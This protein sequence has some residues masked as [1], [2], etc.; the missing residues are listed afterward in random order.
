MRHSTPELLLRIAQADAYGISAEFMNRHPEEPEYQELLEMKRYQGHPCY[1]GIIPARYTDDGQ[2][3]IAVAETLIENGAYPAGVLFVAKF[4]EVFDRDRRKGYSPGF[5]KILEESTDWRA[6]LS[7]LKGASDKNGAA[8]RSVPIGVI[9]DPLTVT[10]VAEKQ[11]V[12]THN[13]WGGIR[14]SQ[15]VAL[16]AHFALHEPGELS[17]LP[18]Y[19]VHH[20]PDL[21]FFKTPWEGAVDWKNVGI[22]TAHA[23]CTLASTKKSLVEIMRQIIVWGGDTDTVAACAWGI[24]CPRMREEKLPEFFDRDLEP[25]GQYGPAF[26]LDLGTRL[27]KEF[28]G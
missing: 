20:L 1:E 3:S 15:A 8:M 10:M 11:A 5:Q 12:M 24:A 22:K 21:D 18:D 13:T 6:M 28:G 19:V 14:S 2:M 4:F 7:K 17:D 23:A 9:S 25:G 16:M 26:L 27:M